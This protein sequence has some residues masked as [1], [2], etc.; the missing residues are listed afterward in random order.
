VVRPEWVLESLKA[1]RRLGEWE[2]AVVKSESAVDLA[3]M[4]GSKKDL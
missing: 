2:F 1:G 3:K 4:F